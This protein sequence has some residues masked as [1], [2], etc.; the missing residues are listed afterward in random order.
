[1][2][3][4]KARQQNIV[5]RIF[6]SNYRFKKRKSRYLGLLRSPETRRFPLPGSQE[7]L[8]LNTD[9]RSFSESVCDGSPKAE[10]RPF[11]STRILSQNLLARSRS[12][13]T[14]ATPFPSRASDPSSSMRVNLWCMSRWE[15]GSSR[16][17]KSVPCASTLAI[18]TLC[19]SLLRASLLFCEK[20]LLD[21][22]AK[23]N[24]RRALCLL[25][26]RFRKFPGTDISRKHYLKY[27]QR[28]IEIRGL[29]EKRYFPVKLSCSVSRDI[30]SVK[31]DASCGGID[32]TGK[33]PEKRG[34]PAP[35]GRLCPEI[36]FF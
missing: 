7:P 24:P 30:L 27:A 19:C 25:R 23:G 14:A 5:N 10:T 17:I 1:M 9:E 12:W 31:Q 2:G 15:D 35:F 8:T 18:D 29:R 21:P 3:P 22:Q 34:F 11:S 20:T 13:R 33:K 6:L 32:Y 36:R 16:K 26:F 4:N 28:K